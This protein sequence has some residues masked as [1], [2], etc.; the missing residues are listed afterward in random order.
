M[1]SAFT[2]Q[3][4]ELRGALEIEERE[5]EDRMAELL[6]RFSQAQRDAE[7]RLQVSSFYLLFYLPAV[8]CLLLLCIERTRRS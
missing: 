7:D 3:M 1:I 6:E 5:R 4:L 8:C 2:A